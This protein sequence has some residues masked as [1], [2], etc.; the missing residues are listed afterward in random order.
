M[1]LKQLIKSEAARAFG[2]TIMT[3][4]VYFL[5]QLSVLSILADHE[6][7]RVGFEPEHESATGFML[8]V[9][10]MV[11]APICLALMMILIHAGKGPGLMER[12][13]LSIPE[14]KSSIFWL[15]IIFLSVLLY[16]GTSLALER[17]LIN[18]FMR[19]IYQTTYFMPLFVISVGIAGPAFEEF[20]FRE[21]LFRPVAESRAGTLGAITLTSIVWAGIHVQYDYFDMGYILLLGIVLGAARH[22]TGSMIIPFMMHTANNLLSIALV[23]ALGDI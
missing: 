7:L 14:M 4:C 22:R 16:M 20:L 23:K 9:S 6:A 15:F 13:N 2:L 21:F 5:I 1:M 19:H 12:L 18:E 17:P 8:S 10:L 11:A 3:L